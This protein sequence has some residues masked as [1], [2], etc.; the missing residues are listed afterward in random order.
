[1]KGNIDEEINVL[2][3]HQKELN[4]KSYSA[5]NC[6]LSV[7]DERNLILIKTD[8][9]NKVLPYNQILKRHKKWTSK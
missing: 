6:N 3:E 5:T 4:I 8:L 9:N 2:K 1:M 7:D